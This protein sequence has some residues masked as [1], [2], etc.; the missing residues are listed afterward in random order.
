MIEEKVANSLKCIGTG[1]NFL[2][3]TPTA[4]HWYQQLLIGPHGT[5]TPSIRQNGSLQNGK[6]SLQTLCPKEGWYPKYIKKIKKL[7]TNKPNNPI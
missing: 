2:Y 1:D 4:Q 5:G 6:R 3:R 7:D